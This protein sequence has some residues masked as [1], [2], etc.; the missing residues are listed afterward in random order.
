MRCAGAGAA[1]LAWFVLGAATEARAQWSAGNL[2]L[3]QSGRPLHASGEVRTDVYDRADFGWQ[4]DGFAAGGRFELDRSSDDRPDFGRLAAYEQLTQRWAEWQGTHARVRVGNYYTLLGHGLLHRSWE[5]PGVVYDESGTLTR[6]AASRDL[7]GVIAHGAWGPLAAQ[8]FG[9][10]PNQATVSPAMEALGLERYA[11]YLQGAQLESALPRGGRVGT[12][13]TRFN[14]GDAPAHEG[15]TGFVQYDLLGFAPGSGMS[16]PF[17]FE[18][19]QQDEHAA[20]WWKLRRG[21]ESAHAMYAS[22]GMLWRAWTLSAEWKDY[23][24]FRFGVNDPPSLVREHSAALLN[25][26]THVLDADGE[27][28]FQIEAS[29]PLAAWGTVTANLTRSDGPPGVRVLRFEERFVEAR[30]APPGEDRWEATV[31][32]SRGFDTFDFVGDRTTL[33]I[34]GTLHGPRGWEV[35]AD[36]QTQGSRTA[37]FF[38]PGV[39]ISDRL[40]TVGVAHRRF[41]SAAVSVTRTDDPADLPYDEFGVPTASHVT[42]VGVQ[43]AAQFDERHSLDLFVGRRRG[44]R[45]CTSGTCYEVPSLDGAEL[46]WVARY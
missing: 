15:A 9:G 34:A 33:G 4:G 5:L 38:G 44:G 45:A 22:L 41:G 25:R 24:R 39:S 3:A 1:L 37:P 8:A 14:Y 32:E 17:Y 7:D 21:P 29:A 11:G 20:E 10:R 30:I 12:A 28:G 16:A 23:D 2:V 42:L 46:R 43:C 27:A 40:F 18:Y 35:S 31:F 36:V 6:Y 26:R 19:A 13:W